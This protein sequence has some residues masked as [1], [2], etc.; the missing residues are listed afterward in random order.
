M[1]RA[2]ASNCLQAALRKSWD[3]GRPDPFT[4]F[5]RLGKAYLAFARTEPAYYSAMF[6]AGIPHD[7]NPELRAGRRSRLRGVAQRHGK[8]ARHDAGAEPAAGADGGLHIWALSHGIASLF[9]RGDAA[10][11]TLP[12]SAGRTAGGGRAGLP[13]RPRL[14]GWQPAAGAERRSPARDGFVKPRPPVRGSAPVDS[15]P[16][17]LYVNVINIHTARVP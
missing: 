5:D 4:A 11:R 7:A 14:S 9:G 2:A 3:D 1:S 17:P 13:A 6:E 16:A 10:R 15:R 12:M 8:I